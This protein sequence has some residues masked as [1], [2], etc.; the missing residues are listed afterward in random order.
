MAA[1]EWP[2]D[3][4]RSRTKR[5]E[6]A[7]ADAVEGD[8]V[9]ALIATISDLAARREPDFFKLADVLAMARKS[10]PKTFEDIIS[11]ARVSRRRAYYLLEVRVR[12]QRFMHDA[13]RLRAI[14]WTKL[15]VLVPY[16]SIENAD[17]LLSLAGTV[18]AHK[19]GQMLR[20]DR[21]PVASHC[22]LLRLTPEQYGL[23]EAAIL[24][25]GGKRR[26]RQ[27]IDQEHAL[28]NIIDWASAHGK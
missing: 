3:R 20:D 25:N 15:K 21:A 5:A 18:S 28:L 27:L 24:A 1:K 8:D 7:D 10:H 19:L 14:G 13:A 26:G 2:T 22:V 6:G 17:E 12:F 9:S 23:Y 4:P 16:I 11:R